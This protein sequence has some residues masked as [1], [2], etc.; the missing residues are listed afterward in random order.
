[1]TLDENNPIIISMNA[2]T[3]DGWAIKV[4][5]NADSF[6]TSE[7]PYAVQLDTWLSA[8]GFQQTLPGLEQGEE[9]SAPIEFVTRYVK[10]NKD[11]TT[12]SQISFW[13]AGDQLQNR[14]AHMYLNTPEDVELFE[15]I[16]GLKLDDVNNVGT[17]GSINKSDDLWKQNAVKVK[18]TFYTVRKWTGDYH[19]KD[20][21]HKR[22]DYRYFEQPSL[23]TPT[24]TTKTPENG[25]Q[26]AGWA[27]R[28]NIMKLV[29]VFQKH[30]GIEDADASDLTRYAGLKS[31]SDYKA[32]MDKYAT[33]QDAI[34]AALAAY[35]K[36]AQ[37]ITGKT[38]MDELEEIA[39]QSLQEANMPK[40]QLDPK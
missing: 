3:P 6:M 9:K 32:W 21:K 15:T 38:P 16:S 30:T 4:S 17:N 2:Y 26:G 35:D 25:S 8:H 23:P 36:E 11:N 14:E 1:M 13:P 20:Q 29:N 5:I 31:A 34:N 10:T 28:K 22:Y 12:T 24:A 18:N 40:G 33:G 39:E 7:S 19:D 27:N 37:P